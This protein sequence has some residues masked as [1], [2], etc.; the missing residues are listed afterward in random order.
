VPVVDVCT[1]WAA[2]LAAAE[3][4]RERGGHQRHDRVR[5]IGLSDATGRHGYVRDWTWPMDDNAQTVVDGPP[6]YA[7][8][9]DPDGVQETQGL[10]LA[11]DQLAPGT[12]GLSWPQHPPSLD[13]VRRLTH[14]R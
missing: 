7:V 10:V 9:L 11:H 14:D 2:S 12:D 8:T 5:V 4:V 1:G 6:W 3:I 13:T